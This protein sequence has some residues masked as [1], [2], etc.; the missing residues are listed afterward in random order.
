MTA[1]AV[2]AKGWCPGVL[3]PMASGDGLIVRVRPWCGAFSIAEARGLAEAAQRFGNGLLDLTRRANLQVRGVSDATL[4]GLQEAL[5]ALGLLDADAGAE[6]VRNVMVGPFAG[7]DARAL[8]AELSQALAGAQGPRDLPAKFGWLVDDAAAPSILDQRGDVAL[9]VVPQGVAIRRGGQWIG[10]AS[11]REAVAVALGASRPL[12]P[13]DRAPES[14]PPPMGI[15]VPF[16]R[17]EAG[18]FLDLLALAPEGG[19]VRL[20]PWRA[21]YL[22]VPRAAARALGFI[23]EAGDPLLRIDACPGAPSC[24]SSTV[25]TRRDAR[26]LAERGFAGTLHIS[27]CAK[28]CARSAPADLVLVGEQGCYGVV[29]NGTTRDRAESYIAPDQL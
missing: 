23:V 19:E 29:H 25:D 28:G 5:R 24:R 15:A 9:C 13:L 4:P 11:R 7:A 2:A 17:L 10:V 16:G 21:L 1:A 27:G 18:Q 3:R 8:A 14:L 26:R 22:D 12:A 6:A 20:A